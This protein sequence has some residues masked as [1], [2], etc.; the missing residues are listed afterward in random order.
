MDSE[1]YRDSIIQRLRTT[2]LLTDDTF[3]RQILAYLYFGTT[4]I[5]RKQCIN[6]VVASLYAA[7]ALR[8]IKRIYIAAEEAYS[9]LLRFFKHAKVY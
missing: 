6:L 2:C 4:L 8:L 5:S 9:R 7:P 3:K 1:K